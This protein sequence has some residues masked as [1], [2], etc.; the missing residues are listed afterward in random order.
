MGAVALEGKEEEYQEF[1][2]GYINLRY[3]L[4]IQVEKVSRKFDIRL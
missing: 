4:Y 1:Y 2:F 3:A